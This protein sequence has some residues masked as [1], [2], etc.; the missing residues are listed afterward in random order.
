MLK[1][2]YLKGSVIIFLMFAVVA[3]IAQMTTV[4]VSNSFA[5]IV[6]QGQEKRTQPEMQGNDVEC[7]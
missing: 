7:R 3:A 5:V 6:V 1:P 2:E 4:Q